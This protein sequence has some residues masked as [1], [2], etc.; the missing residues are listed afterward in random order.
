[1]SAAMS[2]AKAYREKVVG[3]IRASVKRHILDDWNTNAV[4]FGPSFGYRDSSWINRRISNVKADAKNGIQSA[5][6]DVE[7]AA[8]RTDKKNRS[9]MA[10]LI[11]VSIR[12]EVGGHE[13]IDKFRQ[14]NLDR[15]TSLADSEIEELRGILED[16][17]VKSMRVDDLADA[18]ARRLDVTESRAALLARDQTLKLNAAL[19]QKRQTQSGIERYEWSTSGDERVRPMHADL[20]GQEFYWTD[21]PETNEDGDENAPG[22][23]YQCRCV[24]IPIL[25]ELPDDDDDTEDSDD[26]DSEDDD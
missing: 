19:T 9:E 20:D 17:E 10:R 3:G 6:V 1:M 25:P 14:A 2:L 23:D 21:P 16:A 12:K 5:R 15:I 8:T 11:P 13:A 24:P 7:L 18:I 22:E 4:A 26:S